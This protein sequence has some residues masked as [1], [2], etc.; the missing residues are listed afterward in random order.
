MAHAPIIALPLFHLLEALA[1]RRGDQAER[2]ETEQEC[3]HD[4]TG[5]WGGVE[6][7]PTKLQEYGLRVAFRSAQAC[8]FAQID[9]VS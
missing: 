7:S 6:Q 3:A 5:A 1:S 9:L 8:T 2:N 4:G